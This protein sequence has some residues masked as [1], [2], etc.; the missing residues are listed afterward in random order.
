MWMGNPKT[1]L[2]GLGDGDDGTHTYT[3]GCAPT[4][5]LVRPGLTLLSK[6]FNG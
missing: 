3:R 2:H 5:T 6:S 4:L 1:A